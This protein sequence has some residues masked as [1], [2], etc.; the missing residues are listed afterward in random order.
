MKI[1]TKYRI[2]QRVWL[3]IEISEHKDCP[4]CGRLLV[5][6][7]RAVPLPYLI[8]PVTISIGGDSKWMEY[9]LYPEDTERGDTLLGIDEDKIFRTKK[10]CQAF[11]DK[12][13]P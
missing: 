10:D 9:S 5:E 11:I 13:S 7:S 12:G 1:E 3:A 8:R 2:D 4:V 6:E